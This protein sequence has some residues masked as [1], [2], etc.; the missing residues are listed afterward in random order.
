MPEIS[1]QWRQDYEFLECA[2]GE[3]SRAKLGTPIWHPFDMADI[4]HRSR[5]YS[6][7][8]F[9]NGTPVVIK[10][11]GEYIVNSDALL[12]QYKRRGATVRLLSDC[13]PSGKAISEVGFI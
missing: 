1:A 5:D 12:S 9:G 6:I 4:N 11:E 2:T 13:Q 10:Q 7:N 3:T 8:L